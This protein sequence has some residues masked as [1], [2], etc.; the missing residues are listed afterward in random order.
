M[1]TRVAIGGF[2]VLL[3]L[4]CATSHAQ[5]V[6]IRAA[7]GGAAFA[8]GPG[9]GMFGRDALAEAVGVLGELNLA[10]DFNF[11][12]EQKTKIQAI[13][14]EFKRQMD[15]WRKEHADEL[16]QLDDQQQEMFKDM[17]N[18]GAAID[19]GQ[20]MDMMEAR[21]TLWE[22][23]PTGE[24]QAKELEAALTPEQL[25]RYEARRDEIEKERE[26]MMKKMPIR[27]G[28][29]GPGGPGGGPPPGG[30]DTD[31]KGK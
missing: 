18:G 30:K 11:S 8:G 22:T 31:A 14:D 15:D 4:V 13:R 19:P 17:Q 6:I 9:G 5:Q 7:P 29:G 27:F 20:M 10:P 24:S 1:S 25:K 23:A 12:A 16:K 3:G 28:P 21:R 26:E 2:A